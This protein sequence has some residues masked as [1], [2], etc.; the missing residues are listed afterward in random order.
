MDYIDFDDMSQFHFE[1][2]KDYYS[3][4]AKAQRWVKYQERKELIEI[5]KLLNKNDLSTLLL[6]KYKL[7]ENLGIRNGV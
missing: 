3:P 2:P 1:R 4:Y 7:P 6:Y 5:Y